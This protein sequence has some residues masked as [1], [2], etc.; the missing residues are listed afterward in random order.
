M[1]FYWN[2]ILFSTKIFLSFVKFLSGHFGNDLLL[3]FKN[4]IDFSIC[5][6]FGLECPPQ[7]LGVMA[8]FPA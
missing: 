7:C 5:H 1:C 8:W 3:H 2:C 4:L 6:S